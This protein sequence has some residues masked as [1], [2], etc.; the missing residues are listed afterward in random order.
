MLNIRSETAFTVTNLSLP[1]V[2]ELDVRARAKALVRLFQLAE[3]KIKL[4]ENLNQELSIP[5]INELRYA[6]YHM[7]QF[8]ASTGEEADKQLGKAENHCKRAIYDAV[9]AGVTSQ[10]EMIKVFQSD[11]RN[12]IISE[13]ITRYPQIRKQIKAA[14]DLILTPRDPATDRSEYY[15][16]CSIHL[17]IM[18]E[19]HDELES[20]REELIQRIEQ[21]NKEARNRQ[22]A[23]ATLL[24][25]LA[26][27]GYAGLAYH[28]PSPTTITHTVP[29]INPAPA[30]ASQAATA[31]PIELSSKQP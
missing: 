22:V 28:K 3:E 17:E 4:V 19:A 12:V 30:Q 24:V 18:R 13:T 8:L 29:A 20:Y 25:A 15:E 10:L 5:A 26:G 7:T 23:F 1:D 21:Q 14:R 11:F 31:T 2:Q 9:E 6:G 16:Q 27:S